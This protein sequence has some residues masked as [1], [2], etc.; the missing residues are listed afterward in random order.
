MCDF[1]QWID[2]IVDDTIPC[3]QDNQPCFAH[4]R[5]NKLW[6]PLLEKAWSK[7]FS[8]YVKIEGGQSKDVLHDL[9]GASVK[10]F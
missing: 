2:V 6:V 4:G 5:D 1:G 8:S 7:I 10:D 9:T 3:F